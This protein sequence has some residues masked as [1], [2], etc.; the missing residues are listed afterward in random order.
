MAHYAEIDENN[1]VL[2]VIVVR[3]EEEQDAAGNDDEKRGIAFCQSLFGEDTRWVRTSYHGHIRTRYAGIGD[4]YR[5]DLDAFVPPQPYPS[6]ILN[7][8]TA[9]WQAP[10]PLPTDPNNYYTWDEATQSWI[11]HPYPTADTGAA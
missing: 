5:E 3:N 11:A 8:A 2:R 4:T 10:T 9:Q 7:E 6:W 1:I